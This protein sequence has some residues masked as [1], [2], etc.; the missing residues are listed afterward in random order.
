MPPKSCNI[1]TILCTYWEPW[2][3]TLNRSILRSGRRQC[4][5]SKEEIRDVQRIYNAGGGSLCGG[6]GQPLDN[7]WR[8]PTS[9]ICLRQSQDGGTAKYPTGNRRSYSKRSRSALWRGWSSS[10][11]RF[12]WTAN[13]HRSHT[14]CSSKRSDIRFRC[15]FTLEIHS[16][17]T[18][19]PFLLSYQPTARTNSKETGVQS[20]KLN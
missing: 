13:L 2:L 14:T 20:L 7:R 19:F 6:K 4:G 11:H 8:L 18:I 16:T 10:I 12:R 5:N 3:F 1:G 15:I 9:G 17:E